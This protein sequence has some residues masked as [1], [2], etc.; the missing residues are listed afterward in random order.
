MLY[1]ERVKS[2]REE[3]GMT[4]R[5]LATAAGISTATAKNAERGALVR[6]KTAGKVAAALGFNPP[7][8]LGRPTHQP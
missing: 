5:A 1:S 6:S 8:R 7:R 4:N 3:S 2:M